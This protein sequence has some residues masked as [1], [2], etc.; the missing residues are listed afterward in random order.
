VLIKL[1]LALLYL[2]ISILVTELAQKA[3]RVALY[4]FIENYET[5]FIL[6]CLI[7][8]IDNHENYFVVL[9]ILSQFFIVRLLS[10]STQ[11]RSFGLGR[12]VYRSIDR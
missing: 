9:F 8:D 6:Q 10:N 2:L 11:F 12:L 1:C 5:K 3:R 4:F 7:F